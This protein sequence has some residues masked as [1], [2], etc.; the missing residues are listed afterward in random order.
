[1]SNDEFSI[2]WDGLDQLIA[3]FDRMETDLKK[4]LVAE[5]M[6]YGLLVEEGAKALAPHDNG[7]LEASITTDKA[8]IKGESVEMAVGSNS[9]YALRRHEEPYRKG[10][11]PKYDNGSKFPDFYVDGR[12]QITRSKQNWRGQIPGR[13]YLHNAINATDKEYHETN[14]RVLH[15]TLEGDGS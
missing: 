8:S 6:K 7:D 5:Y 4:N 2:K 1:M 12:G 9:K 13:K 15:R 11:F 3:K 14:E 10:T